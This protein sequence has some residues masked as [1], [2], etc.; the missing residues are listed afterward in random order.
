MVLIALTPIY[1]TLGLRFKRLPVMDKSHCVARVRRVSTVNSLAISLQTW[2]F[3]G[4]PQSL[5]LYALQQCIQQEKI[6]LSARE[7]KGMARKEYD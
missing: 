6:N 7:C 3:F 5:H 1:D 2:P 4:N